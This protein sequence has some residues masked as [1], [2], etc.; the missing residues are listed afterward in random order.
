M[1]ENSLARRAYVSENDFSKM[2]APF[3]HW[4]CFPSLHQVCSLQKFLSPCHPLSFEHYVRDST[5]TK[6]Q[7][8]GLINSVPRDAATGL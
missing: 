3:V 8:A 6:P 1:S 7:S 2:L 4:R 5:P